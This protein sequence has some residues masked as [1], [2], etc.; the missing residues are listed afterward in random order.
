MCLLQKKKTT[1]KNCHPKFKTRFYL[2]LELT[3]DLAKTFQP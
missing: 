2:N 3:N 1:I